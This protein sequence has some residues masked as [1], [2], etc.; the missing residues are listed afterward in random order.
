MRQYDMF[1]SSVGLGP[2][3]DIFDKA[4]QK[5]YEYT[6]AQSS[7]QRGRPIQ[8]ECKFLKPVSVQKNG[9]KKRKSK[10]LYERRSV[11]K[12]VLLSDHHLGPATNFSRTRG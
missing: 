7:P 12:S 6:I 8:K 10:L 1:S 9:V 4:Q 2:E 3:I 5:V 11:G